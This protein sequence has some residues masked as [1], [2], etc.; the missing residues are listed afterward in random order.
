MAA[1]EVEV[2]GDIRVLKVNPGDRI[3]VTFRER[4]LSRDRIGAVQQQLQ[5]LFPLNEV[6]IMAGVEDV[7]II[8]HGSDVPSRA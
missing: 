1:V 2:K 8:R 7:R 4:T 6:L 3:V 5:K